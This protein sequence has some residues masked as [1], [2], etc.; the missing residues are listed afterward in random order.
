[1]TFLRIDSILQRIVLLTSLLFSTSWMLAYNDDIEF[2]YVTTADG[3]S[4][5]QVNDIIRDSRGYLWIATSSGLNKY[6]GFRFRNFYHDER[7]STSLPDNN[8]VRLHEDRFGNI[9]VRTYSGLCLFDKRSESFH[10]ASEW[11]ARVGMKGTP[12]RLQV[13]SVG[14]MWIAVDGLGLYYY[15]ISVCRPVLL[16]CGRDIRKVTITDISCTSSETAIIAYNDGVLQ[17]VDSHKR[18]VLWTSYYVH[19]KNKEKNLSYYVYVDKFSNLWVTSK[20]RTWVYS[21]EFRKWFN[22]VNDFLNVYGYNINKKSHIIVKDLE[23]DKNGCLWIA[24]EHDGVYVLYDKERKYKHL[25]AD[26]TRGALSDNTIQRVKL[27]DKGGIWIGTYK[28]GVAYYSPF[29]MMFSTVMLGDVCTIAEDRDG[30]YWCGTN[31]KGI[32][33]YNPVTGMQTASYRKSETGLGSDVIVSSLAA[34]DGAL[35]FGSYDGGLLRLKDGKSKVYRYE[36]G[37]RNGLSDDNVWTLCELPDGRIVIGTLL[38]GLQVLNPADDSFITYNTSN[39]KLAGNSISSLSMMR[40]GKVLV[41]HNS[42][43]SVFDP[44][45][46]SFTNFKSTASGDVL[47]NPLLNQVYE[48]SRSLCWILSNSGI[49]VYD[50]KADKIY[51]LNKQLRGS[52]MVGSSVIEDGDR[53]MWVVSANSLVR[54]R[55]ARKEGK[56]ISS[57]MIFNQY[58]GLQERQFNYRSILRDSHGNIVI[59]G[60]DGINIIN[61]L[62]VGRYQP[63]EHVLFSGIVLFDNPLRVGEKYNGRVVLSNTIDYD[64]NIR[65]RHDENAFTVLLATSNIVIPS[66]S[67]FYY[68]LLGLSDKWLMTPYDQPSVTFTNLTPGK[69]KLE[70]RTVLRDGSISDNVATLNI[71]ID[72]PA[73]LSWYAILLYALGF[74]AVSFLLIRIYLRRRKQKLEVERIQEEARRN[75]IINEERLSFFTNVSHE[76]RTP[77]NLI[78]SPIASLIEEEPNMHR[79]KMLDL[80]LRNAMRLSYLVNQ[81]LD[82][83]KIDQNKMVTEMQVADIVAVI[84]SVAAAFTLYTRKKLCFNINSTI[85]RAVMAFDEDQ[86][87]KIVTNLLGNAF[88]FTPEGGTVDLILDVECDEND[89]QFFIIKIADN[90]IGISDEEKQRVFDKYYQA[91]GKRNGSGGSGLGLSIVKEYVNTHHGKI[92]V[93]DN[94]NGGT[95]FT[96]SLPMGNNAIVVRNEDTKQEEIVVGNVQSTD[97]SVNVKGLEDG[98]EDRRTILLVDDSIDFLDFASDILS[99]KYNVFTA[100]N[101]KEAL[102]FISN[103][104]PDIVL[105]DVMMPLMDGN[106]LC[107]RIKEDSRTRQIPVILLTAR[108]ATEHQK[109]SLESGADDYITKPF[110][111][112]LLCLRIDRLLKWKDFGMSEGA[113]G[114]KIK[115]VLPDVEI[116]SLDEQ[117]VNAAAKYVNENMGNADISVELM[118]SA[119]NIS[120]VQLYKKLLSLTG[121]TPSEFIRDMRLQRAELYLHDSK[122]PIS[123]IAYK[124]GFGTPRAFSKYF[125]E[126]YGCT[127]SEYSKKIKGEI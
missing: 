64:R 2:K 25:V 93:S 22:S 21:S 65:L 76:L 6:D 10:K 91:S 124:V 110:D 1:M 46:G 92:N 31:D 16:R 37:K 47:L 58:D 87:R 18:K 19:N 27:D 75:R 11:M 8:V 113:D 72:E 97:S 82:F 7:V 20:G 125:K 106:E 83:R 59:G 111:I 36:E 40:S 86:I 9:W 50:S 107:R 112:D 33:K 102:D 114:G 49:N 13:D 71:I 60:Q 63:D 67:R 12:S 15:D 54:F 74:V 85:D 80:V 32:V 109:E 81:L 30:N 122:M 117:F 90:G 101:G 35:W 120:R 105:S 79:R 95:V 84:K 44:K 89:E 43:F 127:P 26:N 57:S 119:L 24:T 126:K 51:V 115:P 5:S 68:R 88:K 17:K 14:N 78:T 62:S 98:T 23:N 69:Y 39:S 55:V 52:G 48:D 121:F 108:V 70:V 34:S 53:N 66:K 103:R 4:F 61:P 41:G 77:L 99:V 118:S 29:E 73:Y 104:L 3:L 28:N 42:N 56:W 123:D 45:D 94:K 116:V 38:S 96:I 100:R